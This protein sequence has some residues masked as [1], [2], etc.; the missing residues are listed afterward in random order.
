MAATAAVI[1]A[2]GRGERLGRAIKANI[3]IGGIRLLDRVLSAVGG[4]TPVFLA[5]GA[6]GEADLAA[7]AGTSGIADAP[8]FAGPLAGLAAAL[9]RLA[10]MCDAPE[11]LF[12]V[13]VDTPFMPPGFLNEAL[14]RIGDAE[15]VVARYD[16]QDYPTNALWRTA[17]A[18][19]RLEGASSLKG[20]LAALVTVPLE[21]R[22][23]D[24][25]NPFANLNTPADLDRLSR[26]A[27]AEFGVG[28]AG[29]T[30]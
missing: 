17:A 2:G 23:T 4:A 16:G 28:K 13:A 19:S 11:F 7:P 20:L 1:L 8:G 22:S 6:Y 25:E 10:R 30:R 15:A 24:G 12:S 29:Q 14:A 18:L 5:R 9:D 21:W 27:E 3:E 26:R